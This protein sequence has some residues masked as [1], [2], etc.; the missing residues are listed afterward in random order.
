MC[1]S[2][3]HVCVLATWPSGSSCNIADT[4]TDTWIHQF[5]NTLSVN[6][7]LCAI[8][9]L[10]QLC[11]LA[12]AV[13]LLHSVHLHF[14]RRTAQ[15]THPKEQQ[16]ASPIVLVKAAAATSC[17]LQVAS[18]TQHAARSTQ[19]LSL[20]QL[21]LVCKQQ[22]TAQ[23]NLSIISCICLLVVQFRWNKSI[24][25]PTTNFSLSVFRVQAVCWR[26]LVDYCLNALSK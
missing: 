17:K 15:T 20:R 12:E 7:T 21:G 26:Q 14:P 11:L 2:A 22:L 1:I 4:G 19:H 23:S 25:F 5:T 16:M 3:R 10:G 24:N 6:P 18:C 8:P 13:R 9:R